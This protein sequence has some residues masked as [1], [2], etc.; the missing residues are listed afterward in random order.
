MIEGG[1]PANAAEKVLSA[2][3]HGQQDHRDQSYDQKD[4]Y[5]MNMSVVFH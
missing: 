3:G 4:M 2:R 1:L 5:D